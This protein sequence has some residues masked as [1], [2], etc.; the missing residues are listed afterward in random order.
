MMKKSNNIIK[1]TNLN[2]IRN[3]MK[4]VRMA[5]KPQIAELTRISLVTVGVLMK[6][7]VETGEVVEDSVIQP[8]LGRPATMYKYNEEYNL[9]L[10]IYMH[11]K[12]KKDIANF[13]ICNLYGD[14][15]KSLNKEMECITLESFDLTIST[16]LSQYP[17]IKTIGFGVPGVEVDGRLI[18]SDY[19]G[20][21]DIKLSC[22][23]ENKFKKSVFVE[24][25]VNAAIAGYCY[26][27]LEQKDKCVIGLYFPSKYAPGAGIY[28]NGRLV[29][30]CKG[31]AGE[32]KFLP[33]GIDWDT[34]DHE[35]D[36]VDD[37]IVKVMKTFMCLYNPDAIILYQ[38][39]TECDYVTKLQKLCTTNMEKMMIPEIIVTDELN[40]DF[41]KGMICLALKRLE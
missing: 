26:T 13:A 5:T 21:Q 35:V 32:I 6:E 25:D 3:E 11:E 23:I 1:E 29:K 10:V 2:S 18:L 36:K 15:I 12:K 22:Y 16:L 31:L 19:V 40:T 41:E 38:E 24:N 7:L 20:F 17:N 34:F 9:A 27:H 8:Q 33:L 39:N 14:I 37:I 4:K 30:G 28:I